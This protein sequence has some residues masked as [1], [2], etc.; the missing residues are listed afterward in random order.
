MRWTLSK[1]N[2]QQENGVCRHLVAHLLLHK[3]RKTLV[4][5]LFQF[6]FLNSKINETSSKLT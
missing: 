5:L 4:L 2:E 1:Q 3:F 6:F